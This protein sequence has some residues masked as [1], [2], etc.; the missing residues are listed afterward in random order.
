MKGIY[1]L[2]FPLH[3]EELLENQGF[4]GC[5]PESPFGL[6]RVPDA[7]RLAQPGSNRQSFA[8]SQLFHLVGADCLCLFQPK[9]RQK[10]S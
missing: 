10:N 7:A 6:P 4:G 9:F 2:K 3:S 8:V 5:L 1:I